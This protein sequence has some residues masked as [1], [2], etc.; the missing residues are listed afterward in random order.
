MAQFDL[1]LIAAHLEGLEETIISKL[2]DRAQ[3]YANLRVYKKGQSGFVNENRL[4][5]FEIRLLYQERMDS[6][7]G[8]F[9]VPEERP[10]DKKLPRPRRVAKLPSTG[11]KI[12]GYDK[13]N[14][15]RD[16]LPDYL[17]LIPQ[18]CRKG[19][20][21]HFGSSVEHDVYAVQAISRRIHYGAMFVAECKF[22]TEPALYRK[23]IT[24]RDIG[25]LTENLTRIEVEE[26]IIGRI[27][28]KVEKAQANVN[29]EVRVVI[30]PQVVV[31]FY[32]NTI[33]PLTKKG[34]I[35]YLLNRTL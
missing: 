1:H 31:D 7:F 33:I 16:I 21:G 14:V 10:F 17:N 32:R 12:A 26:R 4:S 30:D 18:I 24:K 28:E 23:L 9:C 34:E 20:D 19:V 2:I 11:L 22:K 35:M 3:F 13:I 5:L 6:Q 25:T 15:T 29:T 8:R 27:H